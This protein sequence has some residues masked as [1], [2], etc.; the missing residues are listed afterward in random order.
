MYT[1]QTLED[2]AQFYQQL[3]AL[4]GVIRTIL[5][6][7]QWSLEKKPV[8]VQGVLNFRT[9]ASQ[10]LPRSIFPSSS[11]QRNCHSRNLIVSGLFRSHKRPLIRCTRVILP[12]VVE[13]SKYAVANV[14]SDCLVWKQTIVSSWTNCAEIGPSG[15]THSDHM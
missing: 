7:R 6:R 13:A 11:R 2:D 4:D 3:R 8:Y 12:V 14:V 5:F 15:A 1:M 10:P 9:S